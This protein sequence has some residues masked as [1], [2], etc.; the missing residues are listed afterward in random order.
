MGKNTNQI[1]TFA[2]LQSI[3]YRIP[4]TITDTNH[5]VTYND[6]TIMNNTTNLANKTKVNLN[7]DSSI[8]NKLIK[9]S[10]VPGS[11]PV[12]FT[13]DNNSSNWNSLTSV[14]MRFVAN[15]LPSVTNKSLCEVWIYRV[16]A[17]N[18]QLAVLYLTT[19]SPDQTIYLPINLAKTSTSGNDMFRFEVKNPNKTYYN[20]YMYVKLTTKLGL[21]VVLGYPTEFHSP[22]EHLGQIF[23]SYTNAIQNIY[24]VDI[25]QNAFTL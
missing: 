24:Q 22:T 2:D 14:P 10:D 8:T 19:N 11:T 13:G 16:G 12:S 18:H 5:C 9:W 17:T 1:A 3:G 4:S 15:D 23:T 6:F 20:P 25:Y 21:D 7:Y